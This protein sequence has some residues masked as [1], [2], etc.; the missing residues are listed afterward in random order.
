MWPL[1]KLKKRDGAVLG[2]GAGWPQGLAHSPRR[3]G[4]GVLSRLQ[5]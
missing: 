4:I 2:L 1:S 3:T 5:L